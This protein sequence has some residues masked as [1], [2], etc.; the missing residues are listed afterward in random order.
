VNRL[1]TPDS[2]KVIVDGEDITRLDKT[3]LRAAR[4]Q[5]GMI[6][7]D[8]NLLNHCTVYQNI[9]FPLTLTKK[10][11]TY[12]KERVHRL[13]QL[14][15]LSARQNH[16]P[17]E[18]SGGQKQRVAIARALANNPPVLLSDEATSA[19]DPETKHHILQLLKKINL[20]L[21]ITI[22]LI[23]HE[24]GV[25]KE[26]CHRLAILENGKIIEESPVLD[27]FSN[28]Q[29]TTAKN[30][31]RTFALHDLPKKL[32]ERLTQIAVEK[33]RP[34]WR[35]SFL[36][37][38]AETPLITELGRIFSLNVSILQAQIEQIRDETV[39]MMLVEISGTSEK[40]LAGKKY[41]QEN[42]IHV[43]ELGYVRSDD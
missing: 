19:L 33:A 23:T 41:L 22:L 38:A 39:G 11:A 35:L 1:E 32:G 37:K 3:Q 15:S 20:E 29:T 14:T 17:A 6:F 12:I 43:E 36:G 18:L 8:F 13:L 34:L 24:M 28:P 30:F 42:N 27:F 10:S 2:G 7:Q 31:A 4:R 5:I 9:A 16:Y 26:I 21:G 25:V 40:I